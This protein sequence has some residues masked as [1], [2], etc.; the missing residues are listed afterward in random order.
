MEGPQQERMADMTKMAST[1]QGKDDVRFSD[2]L[3]DTV[4]VHGLMWAYDYYCR[5]HGMKAWE[6]FFWTGIPAG[7]TEQIWE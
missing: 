7:L 6:F 4:K 1:M 5:K 2:M 3:A